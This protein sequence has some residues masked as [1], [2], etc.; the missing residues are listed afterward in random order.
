MGFLAGVLAGLKT[1]TGN[2]G[3]VGAIEIT[4]ALDN[5]SGFEQGAAYVNPDTKVHV[6]WTNSWTDTAKG[7][8][9]GYF[10]DNHK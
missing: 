3:Y 8:R 4:T 7:K 5:I 6:A 2:I 9:S 1:K 10:H